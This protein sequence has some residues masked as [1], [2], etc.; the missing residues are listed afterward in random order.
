MTQWRLA[1]TGLLERFA[2]LADLRDEVA[3]TRDELASLAKPLATLARDVGLP[4]MADLDVARQARR[5]TTRLA[6]LAETWDEVR[7]EAR[8]RE[9]IAARIDRQRRDLAEHEAK[10]EIWLRRWRAALPVLGLQPEASLVEASAAIDVWKVIPAALDKRSGFARRVD[11]MRRDLAGFEQDARGLLESLAPDLL[12]LAPDE[13]IERLSARLAAARSEAARRKEVAKRK[14]ACDD[15]LHQA[16]T[17]LAKAEEF[18]AGK[19]AMLPEGADPA[20]MHAR[21]ARREV[22]RTAADELRRQLVDQ[23]EGHGE[24]QIRAELDHFDGDRAEAD[25]AALVEEEERLSVEANV[26]FAQIAEAQRQMGL[27][28][29]G[30]G[31]E[32]AWQL[33][34]NAEAEMQEAAR[35]WIVLR[36]ASGMLADA[37]ERHRAGRQDP[38]LQRAGAIFSALTGGAFAGIEQ[39]DEDA[40]A[41]LIG[42]RASGE[43]VRTEGLSEGTC[44]QLYLALR[45]AYVEDYATRA[46]PAPFLADDLFMSFDDMRTAHGLRALAQT[47]E[48]LQCIL[49]THHR[50]VAELARAELGSSADVLEL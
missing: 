6:E 38:L 5:V 27:H 22:E 20:D 36:L 37:L 21:L 7:A 49:F 14:H 12:A 40:A 34:M 42:R 35:E 13:A 33:R 3:L 47:G 45:L 39:S 10:H 1:V 48:H 16:S 18:L 15:A 8:K 25:I 44:D 46:E 2:R 17:D 4:E 23:G 11:G 43:A 50:H 19:I 41:V 24:A 26:T 29:Q 31:S 9:D 32:T 28:L 30:T